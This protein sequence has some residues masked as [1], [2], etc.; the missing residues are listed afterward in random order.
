M[1]HEQLINETVIAWASKK[2]QRENYAFKGLEV[3]A[4]EE[5]ARLTAIIRNGTLTEQEGRYQIEEFLDEKLDEAWAEKEGSLA[6][7]RAEQARDASAREEKTF[8]LHF[9]NGNP[10]GAPRTKEPPICTSPFNHPL[11]EICTGDCY[12]TRQAE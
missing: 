2:S 8:P 9:G 4:T 1:E 3:W 6:D 5:A 12:A 7:L 11:S 10:F